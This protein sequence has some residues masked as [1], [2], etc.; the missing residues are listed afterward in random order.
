VESIQ[1]VQQGDAN[2]RYI[3]TAVSSAVNALLGDRE[4]MDCLS[5]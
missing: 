5:L 2:A 1:V 4:L 3:N